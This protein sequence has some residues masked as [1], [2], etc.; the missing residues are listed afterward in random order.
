MSR[1][2]QI[3]LRARDTLADHKKERWSDDQLIRFLDEAQK[4]L[5]SRARVLRDEITIQIKDGQA[6]YKIPA[7]L[8][9][10]DRISFRN[11]N[12]PLTSY[13]KL[14][15]TIPH[16]VEQRG[17]VSHV[18]FDKQRKGYIRLFPIPDIAEKVNFR[19]ESA[20]MRT[21]YGGLAQA[22]GIV[23]DGAELDESDNPCGVVADIIGF[24]Q[25]MVNG[26]PQLIT[27]SYESFTREGVTTDV[28]FDQPF[29]QVDDR[30]GIITDI[31]GFSFDGDF[32]VITDLYDESLKAEFSSDTGI[33]SGMEYVEDGLVVQYLRNPNTVVDI[34]SE[35]DVDEIWDR[36]LQYYVTFKAFKSDKDTQ[37]RSQ[38]SEEF[39]L[40][41]RELDLAEKVDSMD[42][43]DSNN[44]QY[45]VMYR[46][47]F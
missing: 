33:L 40:Y 18:V 25:T 30:A 47:V 23:C 8:I 45:K 15:K 2:S 41:L 29:T 10:I 42:Y 6:E 28:L 22:L 26:T 16:W 27:Y 5:C 19:V 1:V 17:E 44:E 32:G 37:N 43:T 34:D 20:Y 39:E 7:D 3:L 46:R 35:L 21:P 36:A 24:T 12:I 9:A 11:K 4:D 31:K 38:G 14:D 13:T